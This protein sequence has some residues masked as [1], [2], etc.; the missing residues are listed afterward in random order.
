L[1]VQIKKGKSALIIRKQ[2]I[3]WSDFSELIHQ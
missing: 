3:S 2:I 1:R